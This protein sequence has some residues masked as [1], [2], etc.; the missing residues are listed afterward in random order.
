MWGLKSGSVASTFASK[1][2]MT[3]LLRIADESLPFPILGMLFAE[4]NN[5]K[6]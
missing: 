3:S 4:K 2:M 1:G 5:F 6:N